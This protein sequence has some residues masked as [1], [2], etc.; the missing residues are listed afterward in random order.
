MGLL[1]KESENINKSLLALSNVI[2]ALSEKNVYVNFRDSRL[3]RILQPC[4]T[5]HAKTV[6]IC[7]INQTEDCVG[8]TIN[9]LKFGVAANTIKISAQRNVVA[10][11]SNVV[12]PEKESDPKY[13]EL[14][15]LLMEERR[16]REYL[17]GE[18][19]KL[20]AEIGR[21]KNV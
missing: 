10:S 7:T 14:C 9:T 17:L 1:K 19:I 5:G 11:S 4:L 21:Y 13:D 20:K 3:T 6:V 16:E 18:N 15:E 12:P 2:R 8:E